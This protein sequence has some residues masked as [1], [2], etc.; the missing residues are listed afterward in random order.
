ML[1]EVSF[2]SKESDKTHIESTYNEIVDNGDIDDGIDSIDAD[3]GNGVGNAVPV[4]GREEDPVGGNDPTGPENVRMSDNP[5]AGSGRSPT[6]DSRGNGRLPVESVPTTT[7]HGEEVNK[8]GSSSNQM[9][10]G[11]II[12]LLGVTVILLMVTI[13]I[14]YR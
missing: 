9:F 2:D 13:L 12:G 3:D 7:N 11:L 1:S 6:G 8:R 4:G 14:M 5:A 10:I